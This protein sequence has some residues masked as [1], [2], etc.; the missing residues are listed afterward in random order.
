MVVAGGSVVVVDVVVVDVV[1]VGS[2]VVVVV[3]G[4][5]VVV[6]VIVVVVVVGRGK[7]VVVVVQPS[8]RVCVQPPAATAHASVVQAS[9]SLQKGVRHVALQQASGWPPVSQVSGNSIS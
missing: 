9:R 7:V 5:A 6:V 8:M 3:A 2:S 4:G 1:V